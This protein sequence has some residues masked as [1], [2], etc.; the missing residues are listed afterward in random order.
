MPDRPSFTYWMVECKTP[1]CERAPILI[2]YIGT[3]SDFHIPLLIECRDFSLGCS[4]CKQSHTYSRHDVTFRH[5]NH[6]PIGFESSRAFADATRPETPTVSPSQS[7][8]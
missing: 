8:S 2:D 6:D 7:S 5:S 3:R 4:E 1:S